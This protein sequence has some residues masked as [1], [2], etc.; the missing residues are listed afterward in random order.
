MNLGGP[1]FVLQCTL[2]LKDSDEPGGGCMAW[3]VFLNALCAPV[4][5]G[6]SDE[7]GGCAPSA[8]GGHPPGEGQVDPMRGRAAR[9]AVAQLWWV[10][11]FGDEEHLQVSGLLRPRPR[12]IAEKKNQI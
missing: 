4:W 6:N 12:F 7:L 8:L 2:C 3:M 10:Q 1:R 11:T 5:H 9:A